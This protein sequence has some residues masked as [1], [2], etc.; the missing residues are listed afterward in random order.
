MIHVLLIEDHA[1]IREGIEAMLSKTDDVSC[2]GCCSTPHEFWQVLSLH[3]V[4]VILMDINLPTVNGIDL[5]REVKHKYP[6]VKV[7]ALSINDHP[8]V[9]RQM[10]NSGA[11]GY[12]FKDAEKM[13]ILTG[14]RTV[15]QHKQ[16]FSR[17]IAETMN[18][19][20]RSSLPALT[21]R[22]KE[23]LNLISEGLTSRQIAEKLFVDFT[24]VESHRKNMLSKYGVNNI[25][26]L[27]ALAIR[28]HL[29]DA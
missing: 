2:A 17:T 29:L 8:A 21:R 7:I 16:F 1:L 20:N 23:V 3:P 27:L 6:A 18:K 13:E 5:C 24:T 9:I 14:I 10:M 11:D 12:L 28:E 22:E 15:M 4:D 19:T 25:T 26:A